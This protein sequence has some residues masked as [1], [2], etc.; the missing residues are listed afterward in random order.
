MAFMA[1]GVSYAPHYTKG[2]DFSY[3]NKTYINNDHHEYKNTLK[4]LLIK[5]QSLRTSGPAL[6]MSLASLLAQHL[7]NK[8]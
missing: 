7:Q 8:R 4:Q 5:Y 6:G 2:L 1:R 3:K